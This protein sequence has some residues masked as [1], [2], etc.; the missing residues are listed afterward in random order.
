M[1]LKRLNNKGW[2]PERR[3]AQAAAIRRWCPWTRSTGPRTALGKAVV[4][5]N[6]YKHGGRCAVMRDIENL[7]R[8][9]RYFLTNLRCRLLAQ[10]LKS[11][12]HNTVPRL[13]SLEI[14]CYHRLLI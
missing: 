8:R 4:A 6:A 11:P 10:A 5:Q 7:L 1:H 13:D 14:D 2:T 9:H 3:R 12:L